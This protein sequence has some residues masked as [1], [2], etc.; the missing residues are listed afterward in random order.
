MQLDK[1]ASTLL[2]TLIEKYI[3]EGQP[4]GSRA[5]SQLPGLDVSPATIRNIM[6]DLEEMGLLTSPHTSAGRIPTPKGYR[7]FVDS[8]LTVQDLDRTP[9]LNELTANFKESY[10]AKKIIANAAQTLS[11]LSHFAGVVLTPRTETTIKQIEFVKLSEQKLL[12]VIVDQN[13]NIQNRL[14]MAQQDYSHTQL[15]QASNYIN[16]H[17]KGLTLQEI[18]HHIKTEL[19]QLQDD[20]TQLMQAAIEATSNAEEE[21][22]EEVVISG[23][24][25][26]L[27]VDDLSSNM[28]SLRKLFDLLEQKTSIIQLL[29]ISNKASG[30]Q[31]F[32]GGESTI[33]PVDEMSVITAPYH[34]N[35]QIVG[36][37][38]VIGPT[39]MAY[40]RVIPVVDM[41]AKLLSNALSHT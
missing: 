18:H 33:I 21:D 39:R 12:L 16:T 34:V 27:K 24:K 2:K 26:L 35:N 41:T 36:T 38:G 22:N 1:R 40:E 15:T 31:I 28:L 32:I 6:A 4:V 13:G 3:A 20:I 29:N 17:C 9:L 30:I 14:L 23:E 25:N 5:L 10:S 37:L 11:S 7:V 19:R 8:L